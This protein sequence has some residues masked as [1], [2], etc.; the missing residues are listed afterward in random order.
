MDLIVVSF[1]DVFKFGFST[2]AVILLLSVSCNKG[3][4]V[5]RERLNQV[6]LSDLKNISIFVVPNRKPPKYGNKGRTK[7]QITVLAKSHYVLFI[8]NLI[9]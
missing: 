7:R 1:L 5:I 6:C 9:I 3:A 8:S 4:V 2:G